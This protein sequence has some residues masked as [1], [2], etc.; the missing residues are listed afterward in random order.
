MCSSKKIF[1]HKFDVPRRF[2]KKSKNRMQEKQKL[3]LLADDDREDLEL[4]EEAITGREPHIK[5]HAVTNGKMVIDY[6]EN[7]VNGELPCLIVLDYNMP[8]MN[9]AQVLFH[10]CNN[11]HYAKIP[12]AVWS[13]S[14]NSTFVRE[15]IEKGATTYFL[16]PSNNKQL[17]DLAKEML[18]LCA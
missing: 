8:E 9:G 2:A 6:L 4:L 16:K 1:I 11:P 18:S 17:Q 7:K 3:I 13:T 14:N 5:I 10:I 15:C 12:K